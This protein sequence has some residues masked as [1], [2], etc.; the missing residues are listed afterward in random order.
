[1]MIIFF[2]GGSAD[3]HG[4]TDMPKQPRKKTQRIERLEFFC[5]DGGVKKEGAVVGILTVDEDVGDYSER[6]EVGLSVW[7]TDDRAND[8]RLN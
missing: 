2:M 4:A 7:D 1:M 3:G 8:A 6:A 5:G